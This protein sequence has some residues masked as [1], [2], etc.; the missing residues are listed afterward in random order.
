ML[1]PEKPYSLIAIS[2]G[3]KPLGDQLSGTSPG[4]PHDLRDIFA[5]GDGVIITEAKKV[6]I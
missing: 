3:D 5:V 1:P 6:K 4:F 2:P